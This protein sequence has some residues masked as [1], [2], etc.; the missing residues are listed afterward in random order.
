MEDRRK[1]REFGL[2]ETD[3]KTKQAAQE[4]VE[5]GEDYEVPGAGKLK[6]GKDKI[7]ELKALVND[8]NFS[9]VIEWYQKNNIPLN[10][11][12]DP[13]TG[14]DRF[15][16]P[17]EIA[18]AQKKEEAKL[19]ERPEKYQLPE[20]GKGE[21][22]LQPS[23]YFELREARKKGKQAVQNWFDENRPEFNVQIAKKAVQPDSF[24]NK[25]SV[26]SVADRAAREAGESTF[27]TEMAKSQVEDT[28][29]VLSLGKTAKERIAIA[30]D[31]YKLASNPKYNKVF[32]ILERATPESALGKMISDGISVGRFN[33]GVPQLRQAITQVGGTPEDQDTFR[34]VMNLYTRAM[35]INGNLMKGE[36][37]TSNYEREMQVLMAG[38]IADTPKA[39]MARAEYMKLRGAFDSERSKMYRL[40]S[41]DN[42]N[43]SFDTFK[44]KYPKYENLEDSYYR[45]L[46]NIGN[47]YFPELKN[48]E[49]N[50]GKPSTKSSSG[51]AQGTTGGRLV[52]DPK[53]NDWKR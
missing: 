20:V 1:R 30:D 5:R 7:L 29:S 25:T 19:T 12:K 43:K 53:T 17:E 45:K 52:W 21:Y 44:L 24:G 26:E 31:L 49:T 46:Q 42:P 3:T 15:M 48:I 13:K 8:G 18:L 33:V 38:S 35:F 34:Q 41:E 36:G 14:V 11:I 16:K 28:Q 9:K 32:G 50:D 23:E 27:S 2:R 37:A 10:I 40:W 6:I 4:S 51:S 22:L 39:A 47:K